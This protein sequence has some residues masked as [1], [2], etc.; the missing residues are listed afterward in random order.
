MKL[1][2]NKYINTSQNYTLKNYFEIISSNKIENIKFSINEEKV[3]RKQNNLSV[4]EL[5]NYFDNFLD[6]F[7]KE[8]EFN[9]ETLISFYYQILVI[10]SE[11]ILSYFNAIQLFEKII[12][13]E[14]YFQ[15][16]FDIEDF[17]PQFFT[18][19]LLKLINLYKGTDVELTISNFEENLRRLYNDIKLEDGIYINT[20]KNKRLIRTMRVIVTPTY[21]LFMPYIEDQGNRIMR[22]HRK[23]FE[24]LRLVFKMDDFQDARWNNRFLMEYIKIYLLNGIQIGNKNYLFFCYSQSQFRSMGCWLV[25]ILK[26]YFIKPETAQILKLS[27]NMVQE[28]VRHLHQQPK[29]L[30]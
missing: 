2:N 30:E 19:A 6:K 21:T 3:I 27:Q 15:H 1:I 7:I 24:A 4:F 20:K 8:Y 28:S 26:K 16:N 23:Y 14:N 29:L 25:K 22:E 10:I 5:N 13:N 12:Q 9:T 11:N 18:E 17:K